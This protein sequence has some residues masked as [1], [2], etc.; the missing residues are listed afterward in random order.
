MRLGR[1][2]WFV[3][4]SLKEPNDIL[5]AGAGLP[6][7]G[8]A[9]TAPHKRWARNSVP[10]A[11]GVVAAF[12]S[13]NT[14]GRDAGG[15][16]WGANTDG[17][18]AVALIE[19]ALASSRQRENYRVAICG[20]GGAALG[21]AAS[22]R[23]AGYPVSLIVRDPRRN[24]PLARSLASG[25][26]G[27]ELLDGTTVLINAT[28]GGLTPADP[29]PWNLE[30]F[31]GEVVLEM[32]YEPRVSEFLRSIGQRVRW[33]KWEQLFAEQARRQARLL[34]GVEVTAES[35]RALTEAALELL[36]EDS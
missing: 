6:I 26:G 29:L 33:I 23:E 35:F 15:R 28:G 12:P 1:D 34:Y 5:T 13:W 8:L 22:L 10:P 2:A 7:G 24:M 11:S 31:Q 21:V 25:V 20:A 32:S 17:P 19:S 36:L 14:L 4:F 16:W 18:A 9:V 30:R 3:D 27:E